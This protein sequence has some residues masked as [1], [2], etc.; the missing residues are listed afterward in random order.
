M[1]TERLEINRVTP[2]DKEGYFTN[3]VNDKKV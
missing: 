3:I 2:D 1:I